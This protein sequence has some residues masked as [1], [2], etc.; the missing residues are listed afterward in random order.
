[1]PTIKNVFPSVYGNYFNGLIIEDEKGKLYKLDAGALL[2]QLEGK[3]ILKWR[4][5]IKYRHIDK[6][7]W[8]GG[9]NE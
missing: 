7:D 4:N 8:K 1:M 5:K 9:E 3:K 2:V 6:L